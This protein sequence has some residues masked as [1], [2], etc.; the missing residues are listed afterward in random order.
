VSG[1]KGGHNARMIDR[2]VIDGIFE[3]RERQFRKYGQRETLFKE[4]I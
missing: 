1:P 4:H 2:Q 3:S